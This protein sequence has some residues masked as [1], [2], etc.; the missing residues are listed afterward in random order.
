MNINKAKEIL[1]TQQYVI[2]KKTKKKVFN[3]FGTTQDTIH[4]FGE[5]CAN[6][7]NNVTIG[8]G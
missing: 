3:L 8:F 1:K 4:L 7:A 6:F 2:E 5:T